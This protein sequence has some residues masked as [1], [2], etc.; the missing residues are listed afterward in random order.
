M[1]VFLFWPGSQNGHVPAAPGKE[2]RK[3]ADKHLPVCLAALINSKSKSNSNSSRNSNRN[4]NTYGCSNSNIN[5]N[6]SSNGKNRK[7]SLAPTEPSARTWTLLQSLLGGHL[8]KRA[9]QRTISICAG[10]GHVRATTTGNVITAERC[11]RQMDTI[12]VRKVSFLTKQLEQDLQ[13]TE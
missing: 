6:S 7:E 3:S 1:S 12:C 10:D 4:S 9:P 5:S 11:V 13:D 8:L 2:L